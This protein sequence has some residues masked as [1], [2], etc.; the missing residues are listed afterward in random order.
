[1]KARTLALVG[2]LTASL[3]ACGVRDESLNDVTDTSQDGDTG[4]VVTGSTE[5]PTTGSATGEEG[6]GN[7]VQL[8]FTDA[9]TGF[10][11]NETRSSSLSTEI[12]RITFGELYY[13]IES[14]I[15][16]S[17]G[18]GSNGLNCY[19]PG[20]FS[21]A[22]PNGNGLRPPAQVDLTGGYSE[23]TLEDGQLQSSSYDDEGVVVI[24][25]TGTATHSRVFTGLSVGDLPIC[26]E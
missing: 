23:W 20:N 3:S 21:F 25:S 8:S 4:T 24:N 13:H 2:L 26:E 9:Y 15:D 19:I 5:N 10:W 1:M 18:A 12:V 22:V 16:Q 14:F 7:E 17:S 6:N 11:E